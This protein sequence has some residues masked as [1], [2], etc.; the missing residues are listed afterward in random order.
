MI[1]GTLSFMW[2]K[3]KYVI[4]PE[5]AGLGIVPN[6]MNEK[7]EEGAQKTSNTKGLITWAVIDIALF[8]AFHFLLGLDIIGSFIF[9][10]AI[11]VCGVIITDSSL[12]KNERARVMVI[13]ISAFFVIFFWAAFEHLGCY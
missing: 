2:L 10:T 5:G 13:F 3:N 7:K 9:S 1:L 11:S 4:S 6:Q 12:T 8:L